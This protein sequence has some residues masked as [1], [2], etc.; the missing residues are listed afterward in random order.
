MTLAPACRHIIRFEVDQRAAA[1]VYLAR[2]LWLQG[3]PDQAMRAAEG[4]VAD[5]RA[6]NHAISLC[7]LSPGRHARS[8]LLVG[9]LGRGGTLRRDAA[10]PFGKAC[11]GA[12]ARLWPQLSG[13]CSSSSAAIST[14]GLRL[15]RAAFDEPGAAGSDSRFVTFR[16]WQRPWVVP[17]KSP[18]G[19]P[20]SRRRSP[21]PSAPKNAG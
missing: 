6:A 7:L 1:R 11:A 2:I 10:R 5:A 20:R 9:D 15:L 13:E 14:R 3:L 12:L 19:S 17:G 18:T 8:R 4:S 21:I 16:D